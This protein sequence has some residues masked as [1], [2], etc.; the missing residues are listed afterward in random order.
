MELEATYEDG[1]I[2]F[3]TPVKLKKSR[4]LVRVIIE[5]DAVEIEKEVVHTGGE[6]EP[7]LSKP[8]RERIQNILG[9]YAKER[10]GASI[11]EDRQTLMDASM[12]KHG[13]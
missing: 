11:S 13:Q 3:A 5:D 7:L 1:R 12:E 4:L 2:Y 9:P 6:P 10:A 8:L